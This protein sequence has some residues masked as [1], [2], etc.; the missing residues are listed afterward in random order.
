M[1]LFFVASFLF[2]YFDSLVEEA[3]D[4][5]RDVLTTGL[6]LVHDAS[7]GGEND[8]AEL[9]GREQLDNPLLELGEANVVAGGDDTAL[10]EAIEVVSICLSCS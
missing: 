7:R 9:T 2:A 3:N 1:P 5:A 10:V 8:V 6:L 4:L